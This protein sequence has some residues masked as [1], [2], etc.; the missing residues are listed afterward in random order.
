MPFDGAEFERRYERARTALEAAEFD[1]LLATNFE[2]VEYLGAGAGLDDAW[3]RQFSQSIAFPTLAVVH[4]DGDPILIVHNIFEDVVRQAT[5]GACEVLV[6]YE[7]GPDEVQ[8]YVEM[9]LEALEAV[10]AVTGTIGVEIGAGTTTDLKLGVPLGAF[11]EIRRRLP[12]AEF[13]DGGDALRSLRMAKTDAELEHIRRA[14]AAID[15]T[16]DRVF[17]EIE[18]GMTETD[19]VSLCNRLV[20]EHGARPIWTLACTTPFEILPRPDVT[21]DDGDTLFLDVGATY[22]GYHA[23]YNRMAVVGGATEAQREHNRTVAEVTNELATFVEPGVTPADVVEHCREEYRERGLDQD[24][25]LTSETKI[26]HSIGLT[27]S[28]APQLAGYDETPLEPGMVLCIEPAVTTDDEFF[29]AE[30]IVAVTEDDSEILSGA[31]QRLY[32]I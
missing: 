4:P 9:T 18:P 30:Q 8:P 6:Y 31:E 17:D 21:L 2:T 15:A 7:T 27:L 1:A 20:S 23:D 29:M 12:D 32:R 16:F 28:E 14:T 19:V 5:D 13:A 11:R 26:G 10:G 25:G 22:G 3:Y 24:L